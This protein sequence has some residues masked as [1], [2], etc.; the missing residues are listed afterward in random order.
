MPTLKIQ[1]DNIKLRLSSEIIYKEIAKQDY[2]KKPL[3]PH[4]G[5]SQPARL[6]PFS[7]LGWRAM[8]HCKVEAEHHAP[9]VTSASLGKL[10]QNRDKGLTLILVC[11]E[12]LGEVI[13]H[14]SFLKNY[15]V[16]GL[17]GTCKPPHF[18]ENP[19]QTPK[20]WKSFL[21]NDYTLS[22]K[23]SQAVGKGSGVSVQ[24]SSI[25]KSRPWIC[26]DTWTTICWPFN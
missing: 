22:L 5:G 9:S 12:A 18:L 24:C 1:C 13:F 2:H 6:R 11:S 3:Q 7:G 16:A 21:C 4:H 14:V 20:P 23:H 25:H 26:L 19:C 8:S 10:R 15:I 17:L